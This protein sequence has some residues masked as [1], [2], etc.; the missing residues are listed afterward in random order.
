MPQRSNRSTSVVL[1]AQ[2]E[3]VQYCFDV[4][5]AHLSGGSGPVAAFDEAS[6][7]ELAVA[8]ALSTPALFCKLNKAVARG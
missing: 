3:H 5:S 8:D 6:W 2:P 4:L 1:A 7:C